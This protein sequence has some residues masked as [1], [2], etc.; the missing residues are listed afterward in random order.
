ML[1]IPCR[2]LVAL[3]FCFHAVGAVAD[4]VAP[5]VVASI[6]PIHSLVAGVMGE[7][8]DPLL[9]LDGY[10]SPH[11]YQMRPSDARSLQNAD[12]VIWIG[13]N[14]ETFLD[15]PIENLA[16]DAEVMTLSEIPGMHRVSYREGGIWKA[17][18]ERD[19]HDHDSGEHEE[20]AHDSDEHE[21][22]GH[23]SDEH[24]HESRE[25]DEHAEHEGDDHDHG[26]FDMHL[27]LDPGNARRIVEAVA[28]T[29]ARIDPSRSGSYRDNARATVRRIETTA[30]TIQKRL[31]PVHENGFIVFHDAYRYFEDAFGLNGIG[32]VTVDPS[33]LPGARRLVE[34]RNVLSERGVVCVFS[35]PQFEPDL[36]ETVVEGT[37]IRSG[38]L[39]PIGADIESGPDAWF[40]IMDK[41]ADAFE[42]C[43]GSG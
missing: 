40:M 23:D 7:Q 24:D 6:K 9:L 15:R 20:H 37:G 5:S 30:A 4:D 2:L 22:H 13:R 10:A 11:T 39:D 14:M 25:H 19:D 29:L 8:G 43:L 41:L 38:V 21:E 3:M 42:D 27:W 17:D 1:K 12:L 31:A 33:R 35:E 34:L 18:D 36:V 32:S 16:T 28:D 26:E